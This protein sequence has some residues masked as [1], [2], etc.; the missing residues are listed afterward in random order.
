MQWPNIA[1]L[2]LSLKSTSWYLED[3]LV[4]WGRSPAHPQGKLTR[5]SLHMFCYSKLWCL[6][7]W[8][9]CQQIHM[10]HKQK[11]YAIIMLP[12]DPTP[13]NQSWNQT[14]FYRVLH[15]DFSAVIMGRKKQHI[16]SDKTV[17]Y[18]Q[19]ACSCTGTCCARWSLW[20]LCWIPETSRRGRGVG[21]DPSGSE[22]WGPIPGRTLGESTLPGSQCSHQT[23][24]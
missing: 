18:L 19:K 2:S 11:K 3:D 8:I 12:A 7:R 10:T 6:K 16:W 5:I 1:P 23:L 15:I 22:S 17:N 21:R 9:T 4:V 24:Q 13:K 14:K 20:L